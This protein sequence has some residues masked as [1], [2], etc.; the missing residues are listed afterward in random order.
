MATAE[1]QYPKWWDFNE[2]GDGSKIAGDFIRAGR[3][4]TQNGEKT[5][6]VLLVDGIERT[7]WLHH[8]VLTN[9]FARELHRRTD[10]RFQ[11]GEQIEITQL[12]MRDSQNGGSSYMNY[13]TVFVDGPEVRHEDIFGPP[14]DGQQQP[15][16]PR[17]PQQAPAAG[18][19]SD[20]DV[21]FEPAA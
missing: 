12:G 13:G 10:K 5:F 6:V 21:P 4:F 11:V 16:L 15:Q 2:D 17:G 14:P 20:D 19:G 8:D 7:V 1:S 9:Q 18:G 3:G